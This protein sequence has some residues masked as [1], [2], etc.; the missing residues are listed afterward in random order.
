MINLQYEET[1]R[2]MEEVCY[3]RVECLKSVLS[4]SVAVKKLFDSNIRMFHSACSP[5]YAQTRTQDE[6]LVASSTRTR[7]RCEDHLPTLGHEQPNAWPC[8][9]PHLDRSLTIH[10][11]ARHWHA[12]RSCVQTLGWVLVRVQGQTLI[13]S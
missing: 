2:C 13:G 6:R 9:I 4:A 8:D 7:F 5:Q 11:G 12:S 3:W 1:S 10:V